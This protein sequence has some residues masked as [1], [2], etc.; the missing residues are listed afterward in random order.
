MSKCQIATATNRSIVDGKILTVGSHA[1][2]ELGVGR[3][4]ARPDAVSSWRR[5]WIRCYSNAINICRVEPVLVCI[6]QA[7]VPATIKQDTSRG[8]SYSLCPLAID[9]RTRLGRFDPSQRPPPWSV[10][11]AGRHLLT[12]IAQSQLRLGRRRGV[13]SECPSTRGACVPYAWTRI[14]VSSII[15]AHF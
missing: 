3:R 1:R 4:R 10:A 12:T 7:S 15:S 14:H 9:D 6:R 13:A 8:L 2:N 11:A 5:G